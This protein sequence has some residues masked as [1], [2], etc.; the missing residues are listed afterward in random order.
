MKRWHGNTLAL[1]R[2]FGLMTSKAAD[3]NAP[4]FLGEFGLDAKAYRSGDY[5]AAIYDRLDAHLASG[6]QW[7]YTPGWTLENKDGW[8]GEDFNIIEPNGRRRPNFRPRP[9]PRATAGMPLAFR[10]SQGPTSTLEYSWDHDPSRGVTE[11]FVPG[12]LFPAERTS[13]LATPGI[14]VNRD[15][16][17]QVLLVRSDS[18]RRLSLRLEGPPVRAPSTRR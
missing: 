16:A 3:W 2:A 9:Y 17:R 8:N 15:L 13:C 5:V 1:N 7:N 18:P 14:S 4:L 11:I 10:F 6:A 12:A